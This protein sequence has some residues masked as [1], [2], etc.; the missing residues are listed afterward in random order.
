MNKHVN[1]L[2]KL[3]WNYFLGRMEKQFHLQLLKNSLKS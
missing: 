3:I 2:K 1:F